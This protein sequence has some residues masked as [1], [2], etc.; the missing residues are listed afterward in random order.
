VGAENFFNS[1]QPSLMNH[2]KGLFTITE[3]VI[4]LN[5]KSLSSVGIT[6]RKDMFDTSLLAEI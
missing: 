4:E 5:L 6:G 1:M 2:P 3:E